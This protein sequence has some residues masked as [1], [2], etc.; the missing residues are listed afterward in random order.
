MQ[1]LQERMSHYGEVG[2]HQRSLAS[3]GAQKA[4]E[5]NEIALKN[6]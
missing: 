6:G 2:L 5:N 4:E 3:R 1:N